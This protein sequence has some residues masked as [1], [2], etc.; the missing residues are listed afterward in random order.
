MTSAVNNPNQKRQFFLDGAE[1]SYFGKSVG[2][3][4]ITQLIQKAKEY[5]L[6]LWEKMKSKFSPDHWH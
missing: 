3:F 6:D 2:G 1:F 4:F 5:Y